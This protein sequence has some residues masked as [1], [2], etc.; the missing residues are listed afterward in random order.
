M[1]PNSN[2]AIIQGF[3]VNLKA[4]KSKLI[5]SFWNSC[6]CGRRRCWKLWSETIFEAAHFHFQ[7]HEMYIEMQMRFFWLFYNIHYTVGGV[8]NCLQ[9]HIDVKLSSHKHST[10]FFFLCQEMFH[11]ANDMQYE[12]CL[13]ILSI[14]HRSQDVIKS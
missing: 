9:T 14:I 3:T 5:I 2:N 1:A 11:C 10:L 12:V 6:F 4:G 7:A 13:L 8:V